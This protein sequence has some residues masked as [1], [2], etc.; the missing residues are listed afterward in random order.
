MANDFDFLIGTWDVHNRTLRARL[1]GS[2]EWD[3]FPG[4]AV[5]RPLFGGAANIDEI[6]FPTKGTWGCTVRLHDRDTGLWSLFWVS[7][8]RTVLDPPVIGRFADGRGVFYGD[9][10]YEGRPIRVRYV[11][12]DITATSARWEQAFSV[13]GEQTWETNWTMELTRVS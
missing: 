9:D 5:V 13:D 1:G 12:S 8:E 7:S 10:V 6:E 4:W 3:E 11:W 2:T